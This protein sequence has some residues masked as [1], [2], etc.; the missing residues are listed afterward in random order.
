MGRSSL[1]GLVNSFAF[2]SFAFNSFAVNSFAANGFAFNSFAKVEFSITTFRI[3]QA[4]VKA[5]L[6][7]ITG[8]THLT[9]SPI[10]RPFFTVDSRT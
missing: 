5:V 8:N 4:L 9:L 6:E 3:S 1:W 10:R 7:I 2:N